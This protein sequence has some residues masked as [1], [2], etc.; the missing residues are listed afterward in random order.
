MTVR[1][2]TWLVRIVLGGTFIFSGFCKAV[3]PWGGLYK[4]TDYLN[5]W[6]ID[7]RHEYALLLAGTLATFEFVLG[8]MILLGTYRR[9]TRWLALVFMLFM[10]VLTVYIWIADPVADCGC[11]GE[12]LVISNGATLLKNI[13][14]LAL[15]GIYARFN[16]TVKGVIR[17]RLQWIALVST[18]AYI[19]AIQFYGYHIKPLVD[20]L[21]YPVGSELTADEAADMVFIYEKDGVR[22]EFSAD[23]LPDE[24]WS[25]V[26]RVSSPEA[27]ASVAIF[28]GD[29]DVTAD[30][31]ETEGDQYLLLVSDPDRYGIARSEMA[32]RL[33]EFAETRDASMI[34]VVA[35]NADSIEAW[36]DATGARYPIFTAEDTDIKMLARGDAAVVGLHDGRVAWKTNV[37]ALPPEFPDGEVTPDTLIQTE[38]D[39][40]LIGWTVVWLLSLAVVVTLSLSVG[41]FK[42]MTKKQTVA[43]SRKN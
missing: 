18:C 33:Y 25:F 11:F 36:R 42:R 19:V 28:D 21:P 2:V 15:A 34:A 40:P 17:P 26:E 23:S 4:I 10:T 35:L 39:S 22:K 3:D 41:H 31:I 7:A 37:F 9:A 27:S 6:G 30:V 5:A 16:N 38:Y 1:I 29:E 12:A 13:V 20:F 14:L 43:D 24:S 32:N 8:V